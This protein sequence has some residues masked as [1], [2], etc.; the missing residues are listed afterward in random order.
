MQPPL[1]FA[2]KRGEIVHSAPQAG[3]RVEEGAAR[4]AET[5]CLTGIGVPVGTWLLLWGAQ[6]GPCSRFW[7][8]PVPGTPGLGN[9]LEAK[10]RRAISEVGCEECP[11]VPEGGQRTVPSTCLRHCHFSEEKEYDYDKVQARNK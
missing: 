8:T 9:V 1:V 10:A 7:G 6:Q 2:K 3:L 11:A 5:R 4:I